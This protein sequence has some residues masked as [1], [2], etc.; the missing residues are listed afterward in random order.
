[1]CNLFK[2]T[3]ITFCVFINLQIQKPA[4]LKYDAKALSVPAYTTEKLV[5]MTSKDQEKYVS[6]LADSLSATEKGRS[7]STLANIP[8]TTQQASDLQG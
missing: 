6:T 2:I 7:V 3:G 1:M 5:K 4:S 8:E